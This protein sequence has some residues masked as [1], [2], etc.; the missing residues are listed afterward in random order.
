MLQAILDSPRAPV[1]RDFFDTV[2]ALTEGN[3][4]FIEEILKALTAEGDISFE[5]IPDIPDRKQINLSGIPR[6]IQDAVQRRT[7]Q[8]DESTLQALTLASVMG[9]RFDFRLLQELLG[10][11]EADLMAMLKKLIAAQLVVEE[12][13]DHFAFRHALTRQAIYN[14]LLLRERQSLHRSVAEAIERLHAGASSTDASVDEHAAD[15]SFHYYAG[16]AWE[17][18]LEYSRKAGDQALRFYAQREAIVY[19]SRALVAARQLN[20]PREPEF[21]SARGRAYDILGDFKS[22]SEDFEHA[23]KLARQGRDAHAEWQTLTDLGFLWI[24]RDLQR[25]GEFFHR[26]EELAQQLDEPRLR[27]HSLNHAGNWYFMTGQTRQALQYHRQ[28]LEFF[29]AERDE[30]GTAKTRDL[31]AM[32]K[33]HDGD[34]IGSYEEYRL[35]IPLFRELDDKPGL[36]GALVGASH[37]LNDETD[38]VPSQS[39]QE[40]LQMGEEAVALARQIGWSSGESFAEWGLAVGLANWGH[41]EEALAH[42]QAS[43]RLAMELEQRQRIAGSYY[44]LGHI[45]LL[46][47]QEDLAIENLKQGAGLATEFGSA[48]L[49]G[50]ITTDL[51]HAYLLK[52]E[53]ARARLLL[54]SVSEKET[55]QYTRS[56][57][58]MLW[59]KGNLLLAEKKPAEALRLAEHLLSVK[60]TEGSKQQIQ[61]IP[62]LLKLKGEALFALKQFKKAE[63][64]LDEA[65]RGAEQRELLP[66]LWQIHGLLGWL[67]K[68]QKNSEQAEK[69]FASA[70]QLVDYLAA[71]IQDEP[72]RAGFLHAA[73]ATLPKETKIGRRAAE[74][75]KYGG[76]TPREREV[77]RYLSQGKSNREIAEALVLSERTIENHISNI[78][79]KL[80]FTS[81]AQ[82]AVWAVDKGLGPSGKN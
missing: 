76:L 50:N 22:A 64:A 47:L 3:P 58:R 44:A 13:A 33:M 79:T 75:E 45:Y 74:A 36:V 1:S 4:F 30:A 20:V 43:L 6:T 21:L 5:E 72:L 29:E 66:L 55:G 7:R 53:P 17:K 67:H 11:Q 26:A 14:T 73:S 37:T 9:R 62:A 32:A 59:A 77:A 68:G 27:A 52:E 54:D 69:E 38:L 56:E 61:P 42:A 19:Y 35:T 60:G 10:V 2:F 71:T 39:R 63:Q 81:R 46:M 70:R 51:A 80:G 48:W 49:I 24:T 31:L 15:L 40:N 12:T 78:L 28:A 25:A 18:A 8:L 23:L 82:V 65:K 34:Q 57:R 41:F 16:A